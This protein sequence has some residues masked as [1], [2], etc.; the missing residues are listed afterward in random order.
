M[1]TTA[2]TTVLATNLGFPR[3]GAQRELK[4]TVEAYWSGAITKT[5]L[6]QVG[7]DLRAKHWAIQRDSG[8]DHIPS[9]D[10]S[11]YDQVL[12]TIVALG[13]IPERYSALI[14]T[15]TSNGPIPSEDLLPAYFA[16][17]RGYQKDGIDVV[18]MEMTK[19]FDTNYHH[20]VPEFNETEMGYKLMSTK[21]VDEYLEAKALGIET[22]PVI[23]GPITI[24]LLGKAKN[25]TPTTQADVVVKILPVY[26][27]LLSLLIDSGCRWVQ[28]DEPVLAAFDLTDEQKALFKVAYDDLWTVY[29]PSSLKVLIGTYFD[30]LRDNLTTATSLPIHALH[31]DLCRT[32][33]KAN[34]VSNDAE[35]DIANVVEKIKDTGIILSLGIVDSRNIW[36]TDL[37]R[38]LCLLK[39]AVTALGPDR[40]WVAG[41]ASLLHS[42]VDLSFETKL[43]ADLKQWFAFAVQKLREI[44]TL[45]AA[46]NGADVAAALAES[47]QVAESRRTSTKIHD[48]TVKDRCA[49]I[50]PDQLSRKN[51][52]SIREQVQKDAFGLPPFPTTTIGSFPQTAEIRSTRAQ[53]KAGKLTKEDYTAT[54]QAEIKKVVDFQLDADIDVLVHGE[55]ERNDMVEYFGEQLSGFCFT[56]NGWVQSY[57][58]RCVKPAIIYGDVSRPSPMTVQ[59][60]QYAQS[61]TAKPMK[62][63]LTG[64]ITILM[65]TFVRDD[66]PRQVTAQQLALAIRDEVADLE[67]GGITIIQIDEAALR[68]GLPLR[69]SDHQHYLQWAVDSFKLA[70]C[71]VED[72][73]QIHTHLCY[74]D[75]NLI[76]STLGALDTD[77]ISIETSRSH[78]ELLDAFV[79]Y[80]YPNHIGPGVYDIHSP[81][82]PTQ[83]EMEDLLRLATKVLKPSSIWVNPDCGLKTRGWA[84]VEAALR[85][86]VAAAKTLRAE[87]K[88]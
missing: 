69:K 15:G 84:E 65:W 54:I 55:P 67:K 12:D 60:S 83:A 22:R 76:I 29:S 75:F 25:P 68:E 23:I 47:D 30:S 34:A 62:G 87:H 17:A 71:C 24:A 64:P 86:M 57:G 20:I 44:K 52:F 88:E 63:M 7:K 77:S 58:S 19:W 8:L 35:V 28:I 32:P 78:M 81:R 85:L 33:G 53:F 27:Q 43:S 3:I 59:W 74:S 42:P 5:E 16:M 26:K 37:T 13:A 41:S 45:A 10:F 66:Q 18:A 21:I 11:Y 2:S 82:V 39:I 1:P 80:Q 51:P 6:L 72:K 46:L 50:T 61:L 70:S 40:V 31:I 79:K 14:P 38:A 48:Q 4:K 9:N 49:A 36:K 56:Q 73:T